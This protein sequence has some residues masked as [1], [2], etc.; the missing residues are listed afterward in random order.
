SAPAAASG[1]GG[2]GPAAARSWPAAAALAWRSVGSVCGSRASSSAAAPSA[3]PTRDSRPLPILRREP[4]SP[5][6]R[7]AA[8]GFLAAAP[9]LS[10]DAAHSAVESRTCGCT[11]RLSRTRPAAPPAASV[12]PCGIAHTSPGSTATSPRFS[13]PNSPLI[14]LVELGYILCVSTASPPGYILNGAI[15]VNAFA[16]PDV[17]G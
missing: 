8:C 10:R 14:L 12:P 11:L 13:N 6:C 4:K 17:V 15:R 3:A 7:T 16:Q 9:A 5:A 2:D 1:A